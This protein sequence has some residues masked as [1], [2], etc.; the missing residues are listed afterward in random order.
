MSTK[1]IEKICP[2]LMMILIILLLVGLSIKIVFFSGNK[3]LIPIRVNHNLEDVDFNV[4][5]GFDLLE[6]Y[7][8]YFIKSD[9]EVEIQLKLLRNN[10]ESLKPSKITYQEKEII[11]KII[12][13]IWLGSKSFPQ[14]Y[15]YYLETW[16]QFHPLWEIKLWDDKAILKENFLSQD[17]YNQAESYAEKADIARYEILYKYGGLYVDADYEC[18]A[19]FDELHYKYSFYANIEPFV[20]N[21]GFVQIANSM[22]G[23]VPNNTILLDTLKI[24]RKD[25]D[26]NKNNFLKKFAYHSSKPSRS[27]HHLAVQRTMLP[28]TEAV[29]NA[30]LEGDSM[31]KAKAI[32]L[33]LGYNMPIYPSNYNY[34]YKVIIKPETR[35][36][37]HYDKENSLIE[38]LGFTRSLFNFEFILDD[39][40]EVFNQQRYIYLNFQDLYRNNF[41][42]QISF[43]KLAQIPKIIYL[44]NDQL[45]E[46]K[47]QNSNLFF[48]IKPINDQDLLNY[49]PK[50]LEIKDV[51]VAK[52]VASFYLLKE[53]GGVFVNKNF[54]PT[55][56]QEFNHKYDFYGI[57]NIV[58]QKQNLMD[59]SFNLVAAKANHK[60]I[61]SFI[62]KVEEELLRLKQIDVNKLKDIYME[63]VYTFNNVDG[64]NIL[65]PEVIFEQKR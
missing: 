64:D 25:W 18:L 58:Q 23:T 35:S 19:S 61:I 60:I 17:L 2:G 10:Y 20:I 32:I 13:I 50:K 40:V 56:L 34:L 41:P 9:R 42:T 39:E 30:L 3:D 52:I 24:I 63:V 45:S 21:K 5:N 37:H 12:H 31:M 28:F 14:N 26:F 38:N 54:K 1:G 65:F 49:L 22:I 48:E 44:N 43:K 55:D 29:F 57:L 62:E 46:E 47:W 27:K 11:P 53:M 6:K 51:E 4:S 33:P 16:H 15:Q 36:V 59:I 7:D 8:V